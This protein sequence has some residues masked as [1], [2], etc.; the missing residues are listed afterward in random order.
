MRPRSRS[1]LE[2]QIDRHLAERHAL[3][4]ELLGIAHRVL[5]EDVSARC[6]V[7]R[8]MIP[9]RL[10]RVRS[11]SGLLQA[12]MLTDGQGSMV[13]AARAWRGLRVRSC[14]ECE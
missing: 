12:P 6:V 14:D 4:E 9:A 11:V 1:A 7:R 13:A 2:P 10:R 8:V 3:V 5:D